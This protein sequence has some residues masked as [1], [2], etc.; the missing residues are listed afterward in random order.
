MRRQRIEIGCRIALLEERLSNPCYDNLFM[1]LSEK[2][3]AADAMAS[4]LPPH[5]RNPACYI[6]GKDNACFPGKGFTLS[7]DEKRFSEYRPF[8]FVLPGWQK[9]ADTVSLFS[10]SLAIIWVIISCGFFLF[11]TL[12]EIG[13]RT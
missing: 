9:L 8:Q 12:R 2:S 3:L 4:G 13:S 6:Y 7:E 11:K 1:R 10:I 5:L